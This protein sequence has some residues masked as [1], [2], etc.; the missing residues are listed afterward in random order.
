MA[1][2]MGIEFEEKLNKEIELVIQKRVNELFD[3]AIKQIEQK[4][5]EIVGGI[6]ISIKRTVDVHALNDRVIFTVREIKT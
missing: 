1:I 2:S 6:L 3:E 5:N 4:K